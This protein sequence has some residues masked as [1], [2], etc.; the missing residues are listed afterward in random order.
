M[1][2]RVLPSVAVA[3]VLVA[4]VLAAVEDNLVGDP[5]GGK[6]LRSLVSLVVLTKKIFQYREVT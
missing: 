2:G 1:D 5:A 3:L 4:A 6:F